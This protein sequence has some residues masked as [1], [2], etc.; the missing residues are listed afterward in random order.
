M[1][2]V[3]FEG[4]R[5]LF[6]SLHVWQSL[7]FSK[8]QQIALKTNHYSGTPQRK[9]KQ[10]ED[11]SKSLCRALL[12]LS[13]GLETMAYTKGDPRWLQLRGRLDHLRNKGVDTT[14]LKSSFSPLA[15]FLLFLPRISIQSQ[16]FVSECSWCPSDLGQ[17]L[18]DCRERGRKFSAV[19]HSSC[20]SCVA[21]PL[22]RWRG[23]EQHMD[24]RNWL[25]GWV[26]LQKQS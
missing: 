16:I 18:A 3:L 11:R 22:W 4:K 19:E 23:C 25:Y 2:R 5:S 24:N 8:N 13:S 21:P 6:L 15:S 7:T 14:V 12:A 17:G 9:I 26:D 20:C 10:D 1:S